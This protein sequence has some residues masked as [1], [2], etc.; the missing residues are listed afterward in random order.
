MTRAVGQ[1]EYIPCTRTQEGRYRYRA[2]FHCFIPDISDDVEGEGRRHSYGRFNFKGQNVMKPFYPLMQGRRKWSER[3][4]PP[5]RKEAEE[6]D[7]P[8]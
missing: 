3:T 6:R 8:E 2:I 5:G 4:P 1:V 7:I